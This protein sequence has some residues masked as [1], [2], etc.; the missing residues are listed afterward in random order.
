MAGFT[1]DDW[2]TGM[3]GTIRVTV[4]WYIFAYYVTM[5][6]FCEGNFTIDSFLILRGGRGIWLIVYASE[7]ISPKFVTSIE[8]IGFVKTLVAAGFFIIPFFIFNQ[9][10]LTGLKPPGL[11]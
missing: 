6:H 3:T 9:I 11:S 2:V 8:T 1:G 4:A 5:Q 7:K 10:K